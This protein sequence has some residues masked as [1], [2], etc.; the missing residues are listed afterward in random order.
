MLIPSGNARNKHKTEQFLFDLVQKC[1]EGLNNRVEFY[2]TAMA[3]YEHGKKEIDPTPAQYNLLATNTDKLTSFLHSKENVRLTISPVDS[4]NIAAV[5]RA[6]IATRALN[7][8]YKSTSMA[9]IVA[10]AVKLGTILSNCFGVVDIKSSNS[11]QPRIVLPT[12]MSL[13]RDDVL[14][15]SDQEAFV[16]TCVVDKHEV[17]RAI[18]GLP[19]E[20]ELDKSLRRMARDRQADDGMTLATTVGRIVLSQVTPTVRGNVDWPGNA[21]N[22]YRRN[23]VHDALLLHKI[24]IWD[25]ERDEGR[26]D[27]SQFLFI[28]P[29]I[30]L[31]GKY[32][33]VNPFY[34]KH[35]PYFHVVPFERP[36][37]AYGTCIPQRAWLLQDRINER[38][39]QIW[40]LQD[41][42]VD[43]S[44]ALLGAMDDPEEVKKVINTPGAIW[45]NETATAKVQDITPPLP[46]DVY[47]EYKK[48]EEMIATQFWLNDLLQGKGETGVRSRS[49]A[50]LLSRMSAGPIRDA[51]L[52][53][54]PQIA[55]AGDVLF[56][57]KQKTDKT[58]YRVD[59]AGEDRFLLGQFD[60]D[61]Y[62]EV[63]AHST[64]PVFLEEIEDKLFELHTR[65]VID[66]VALLSEI[67]VP[68]KD[69]LIVSLKERI[70]N[71]QQLETQ[72][73]S[74]QQSTRG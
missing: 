69:Q 39:E 13:Y 70:R 27:Y 68:N 4:S 37:Y 2:R 43:H 51:A 58:V 24:W 38:V 52:S 7:S 32:K 30:I 25:D 41:L 20:E 40:R 60:Y 72:S 34:P 64:S 18:R 17:A 47:D 67:S 35:Q 14:D 11:I 5:K 48:L 42:N 46:I 45:I 66:G 15:I 19:N 26:G 44:F 62:L 31:R 28:E 16:H 59:D 73:Q 3:Y 54:E 29:D 23:T 1:R 56:K 63:D 61:Y 55:R 9:D 53:L 74:A 36:G 65:Q 12:E 6:S 50:T 57:A 33:R 21:F 22:P 71:A 8:S 10:T 49:H